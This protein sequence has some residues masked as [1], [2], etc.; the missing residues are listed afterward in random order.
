MIYTKWTGKPV[1][2][3]GWYSGI[4]LEKYHSAGICDA[5]AVSSTNLRTCWSKSPAHMFYEWCENPDAQ[6]K[7]VSR[8][9]LLGAVGH[10]I[11]LGEDNFKTKYVA[12]PEE[13]RD[14]VTAKLKPWHNGAD[15]CK[16]WHADQLAKGRTV[17][18]ISQLNTIVAMA[19]SL[20]LE[21]LVQQGMLKG[22]VECSGFFKDTETGLW[23]KIRPDVIPVVDGYF[24]D[25]KLTSEVTTPAI[26]YSIRTYGYHQQGALIW[27]VVEHIHK[28]PFEEFV[29]MCVET[30]PPYCSR[31]FPID[32]D[33]LLRGRK[34]NRAMLRRI[35]EC[36]VLGHW[37]GPGEGDLHAIPIAN[38][39]RN[40]IDIR[41]KFEGITT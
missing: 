7:K 9:M 13:Y 24:V 33:D 21:P 40:R 17:T 30:A 26:Q 29:L 28:A 1:T 36:Q 14:K 20:A 22:D 32:R 6:P 11:L 41:L 19:R 16:A 18:T 39:E 35:A 5:P 27:E 37:P 23:L 25:L 2:K 31:A 4:P 8:E 15:Y 38:D 3:P 10:F 12:Q 34:Q